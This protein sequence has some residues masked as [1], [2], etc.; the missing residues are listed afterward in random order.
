MPRKSS[1]KHQTGQVRIIAGQCRGRR[2]SFPAVEGL[3]PTGDRLR[4]TLFNWLSN[5]ISGARCLDLF[6]GSGALGLEAASRGAGE[7]FLIERNNAVAQSLRGN[8]ALLNLNSIKVINDDAL[9]WLKQQTDSTSPFDI[10]FL[11]PPFHSTLLTKAIAALA[12]Q[13]SLLASGAMIYVE[14]ATNQTPNT[15]HQNWRLHR[16]KSAGDVNCRLYIAE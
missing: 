10:V 13:S 8:V 4:E 16:Q 12:Q 2:V 11:D 5:S 3:R 15:I 1:N 9:S 14:S 6:A 7:V